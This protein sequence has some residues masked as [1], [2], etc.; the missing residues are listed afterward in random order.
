MMDNPREAAGWDEKYDVVVIGSGFAGLSAAIEAREK[1]AAVLVIEKMK[2]TGGNSRISDGG[3]AAPDT[4]IQRKAGVA[5]SRELFYKDIMHSGLNIN[6]PGLV[7]LLVDNAADAFTWSRDN[8]GVNYLDRIDIFG[9]HSAKRCYTADKISGSTIIN[10]QLERLDELGVEVRR[11]TAFRGYVRSGSGAVSGI[12]AVTVGGGSGGA[13]EPGASEMRLGA[14]KGVVLASGGYG[15]DVSFRSLQDP[16]LDE[17]VDTT[18]RHSATA[19]A[20]KATLSIGALPVH[21]SS[22][23]LGPW[24]SP[25]EKGFGHGPMFADYIVFPYGII[26]DPATGGRFVNELADRKRLS[27]AILAAGHPCVAVADAAAVKNAGWDISK[28][29]KTGVVRTF[30]TLEELAS[31]YEMPA[32][33]FGAAISAFNE[34]VSAGRDGDFGKPIIEDAGPLNKAPFYAMRVWPKVHH[35]SGGVGINTRAQVI[36]LNGKPIP[37][38]FAA[39][40]VA[41]GIHGANRLGSCAITECFVFGRI[42]GANAASGKLG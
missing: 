22:I 37:G 30:D 14:Q 29:L 33:G 42:A 27:D 5:D 3:I 4:D 8:L 20:L 36:D 12:I 6:H 25:D 11:E 10:R 40:E 41:G 31:V 19:E 26:V 18:N 2:S 39:G 16:R 17:S 23:Q 32:D 38:L 24:A 13:G 34:A 35:V 9:G 21:L 7:R 15:A 1:G 28:A